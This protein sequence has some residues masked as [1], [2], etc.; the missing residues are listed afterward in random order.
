MPK[1]KFAAALAII[2]LAGFSAPPCQAQFDIDGLR[3]SGNTAQTQ[4]QGFDQGDPLRLTWGFALEGMT[5]GQFSSEANSPNIIRSFFDGI[6]GSQATWQPLFQSTFDRWASISGLEYSFETADDGSAWVTSDGSLGVRAD[7]RISAHSIDGQS[8]PDT[9]AY[10]F[11]PN[12]GDMVIDSDNVTF[13]SNAGTDNF[14]GTRNVIAHEHGHGVGMDHLTSS[15]SEQLMEP[16]TSSD[17]AYDGPQYFD[18]LAAQR[19]YGD[20]NEKSFAQLGNDVV[21]R[22]TDLGLIADGATLAIGQDAGT[23]I[24][25]SSSE[26]F[27]SI[28]DTTDTDFYSVMFAESGSVDIVLEALGFSIDVNGTQ[29]DTRER[30]DLELTFYDTDGVSILGTSNLTG[31]GGTESLTGIAVNAGTYFLEIEGLD[32]GDANIFD[33]QFYGLQASFTSSAVPEP[34]SF[35]VL[36]LGALG[37]ILCRR[38][39]FLV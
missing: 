14:R 5:V 9:L 3:W 12:S 19:G 36:G 37:L 34:G 33:V 6:H 11:F 30:S 7:V 38:R 1:S 24:V 15:D 18:I 32:N 17:P 28:D 29:F 35:A 16:S 26:D 22:A 10:N 27:V 4:A 23:L 21:A 39:K 13:Y 25:D 8:P 20:F 2:V 31:L